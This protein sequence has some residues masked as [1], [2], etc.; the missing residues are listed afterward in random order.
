MKVDPVFPTASYSAVVLLAHEELYC[1]LNDDS[2]IVDP[3][4]TS[5]SKHLK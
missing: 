3:G 1:K 2:I 4:E 5:Q